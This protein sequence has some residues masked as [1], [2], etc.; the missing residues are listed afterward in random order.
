MVLPVGRAEPDSQD[1]GENSRTQVFSWQPPQEPEDRYEPAVTSVYEPRSEASKI[2]GNNVEQHE[3]DSIEDYMARLLQ[4]V[5]GDSAPAAEP[6]VRMSSSRTT[7]PVEAP[8]LS[9]PAASGE[10]FPE[11]AAESAAEVPAEEPREFVPRRAPDKSVNLAA[12]RELANQSARSAI[13]KSHKQRRTS[14]ATGSL[15]IAGGALAAGA[16]LIAYS[17]DF[18]TLLFCGGVASLAV[19]AIFGSRGVWLWKQAHNLPK[20]DASAKP[21]AA[22]PANTNS[23][24]A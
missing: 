1:E 12:M 5:R 8:G 14:K 11:P 22:Q 24:E 17:P 2:Q 10:T 9:D 4:R 23:S 3:E 19:G 21:D 7:A 15:G 18:H 6:S 16:G 13:V 20:S